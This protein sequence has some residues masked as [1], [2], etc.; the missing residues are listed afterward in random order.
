MLSIQKFY[1]QIVKPAVN[2]KLAMEILFIP[3]KLVNHYKSG[4]TTAT[5]P[6]NQFTTSTPQTTLALKSFETLSLY[7]SMI[8]YFKSNLIS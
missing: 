3:W 1:E 6:E 4:L 2:L 7:E 8:C 5:L